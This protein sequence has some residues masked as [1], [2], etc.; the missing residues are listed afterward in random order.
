MTIKT[1][2]MPKIRTTY[3]TFTTIKYNEYQIGDFDENFQNLLKIRTPLCSNSFRFVLT[4]SGDMFT[5]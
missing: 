4:F 5:M 3:E 1:R 2:A